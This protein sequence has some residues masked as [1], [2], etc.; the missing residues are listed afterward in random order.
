MIIL[1]QKLL[2]IKYYIKMF[3]I[4]NLGT[5]TDSKDNQYT[6]ALSYHMNG[7]QLLL[8]AKCG[9]IQVLNQG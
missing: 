4:L 6:L 7:L 3:S 9:D 2:K 5:I 8:I 1:L